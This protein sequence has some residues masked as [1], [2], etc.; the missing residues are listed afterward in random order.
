MSEHPSEETKRSAPPAAGEGSEPSLEASD[1][2]AYRVQLPNFEGPLDLL[3]HLI[4]KHELDIL[5]IPIGFISEKFVEYIRLMEELSIDVAAEYLVM[6][7]TLAHIKSRSLL[8][9]DPSQAEDDD[10]PEEEEDPRA[11]LIRR[12]LEYQKYKDAAAN[13]GDRTVLGRDIFPRGAP[14]EQTTGPAPL[15]PLSLFKLM[16]AFEAVLKRAKQVEDHQI[17]FERISIS[18][19]IG[20]IAELLQA[21]GELRF[22][23]LF[24]DHATRAEMI[25]TFLALLEMTKL[26]MTHLRQD[27]PLQ[28]IYVSLAVSGDSDP[29]GT[30]ELR[31]SQPEDG[32]RAAPEELIRAEGERSSASQS[33]DTKPGPAADPS[34]GSGEE[35]DPSLGSGEEADP[36]DPSSGSGEEADPDASAAQSRGSDES[37]PE[38]SVQQ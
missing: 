8:P 19:R 21:Q 7:A 18:E 3:L 12:L 34:S 30:D 27:G 1:P 29:A 20:Q 36:A 6:A 32:V 22:E 16:D 23:E 37:G 38:G 13:L 5:S 2:N 31:G 28:P 15:A 11:E 10:L 14:I 26:R 35:A 24:E 17:D 25:V 4:Q 9:P 33:D